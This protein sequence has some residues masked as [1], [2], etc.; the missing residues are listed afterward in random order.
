MYYIHLFSQ[1][2]CGIDRRDIIF[3]VKDTEDVVK[4]STVCIRTPQSVRFP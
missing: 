1:Q 3:T 2:L 4:N